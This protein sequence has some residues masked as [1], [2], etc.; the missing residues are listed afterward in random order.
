MKKAILAAVAAFGLAVSAQAA[1]E[2]ND[3][4][5][6]ADGNLVGNVP[7]V[8]GAWATHSGTTGPVLVSGGKISIVQGAAQDVNVPFANGSMGAG[9]IYYAA[10]DLTVA[11]P[12]AAV[13][14]VYF[15]HF[16]DGTSNFT[17]RLWMTIPTTSGYRLGFSNDSSISDADGEVFTGDLSFGT[18][19]RVVSSY[20]YDTGAGTLWI[21]PTDFSSAS[22]SA[23]D[24][25]FSN[26]ADGYAFRQAAG[27]TTQV[28]DNLVVGT[29]FSDV[30]VPE[31]TMLGLLGLAGLT[32]VSRRR[33]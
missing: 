3:T 22:I 7:A 12:G 30:V 14:P 20:N 23:A 15:A 21:N 2:V 16:L 25:G 10:F 9:D 31:P 28:I 17:S 6:Y 32:L 24:P 11:D 4:F 8:G 5:T 26:T 13:T 1:I 29:S 33:D 27:N 19:Y 18:T